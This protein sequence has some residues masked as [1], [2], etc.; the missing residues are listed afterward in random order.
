MYSLFGVLQRTTPP[1]LLASPRPPT[2]GANKYPSSVRL[3][4]ACAAGR[5]FDHQV[6]TATTATHNSEAIRSAEHLLTR[7]CMAN[8]NLACPRGDFNRRACETIMVV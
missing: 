5:P 4:D 7:S 2:P 3:Q 1:M 8:A 6:T